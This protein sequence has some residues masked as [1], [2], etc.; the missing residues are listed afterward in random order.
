MKD[1]KRYQ[2]HTSGGKVALTLLLPP[3]MNKLTR[4]LALL[5]TVFAFAHAASAQPTTG[6]TYQGVLLSN[7]NPL[8]DN[9]YDFQC[10]IYDTIGILASA[11]PY[12]GVG[13]T[14]GL[15]TL[16]IDVGT[17]PWSACDKRWLE[18]D[19]RPAGGGTWQTLTPR[20]L[21]TPTPF[22]LAAYMACTVR[23][24]SVS[25]VSIASGQ[26]VK[27]LNNLK[28]AVTLSAGA[29]V[30]L[31]TF[32]NNIQISAT[33]GAG[34]EWAL[35]GNAGTAAGD[36]L[37]TTDY[38]P[39]TLKV[40]GVTA[41]EVR[42]SVGTI[43]NIVG[44]LASFRPAVV[45][46]NVS[47]VVIAGGNAPSG[48]FS[49][50]QP[51]DFMAAYDDDGTIGGGFANKV[52]TDNPD[53]TDAA[54]ATVGGGVQNTAAAFAATVGG[55]AANLASGGR[56]VVAGGNVNYAIGDCSFIGGGS[57]NI[58]RGTAAG[59]AVAGG[60]RN[61]IETN[62]YAAII[63]GGEQNV[64]DRSSPYATIGGGSYNSTIGPASVIAGGSHN[65][66]SFGYVTIS[67]GS[68]NN[69][70]GYAA[71]VG[72]GEANSASGARSV[73]AGGY[74]NQVMGDFSSV[75]GGSFNT[76][77]G[78]FA[79][80]AGGANNICLTDYGAI[81]GGCSNYVNGLYSLAAGQQAI[82]T[83]IGAFV[84]ADSQNAPFY[85]TTN[86]EFSIRARSGVRLN[87]DTALVFGDTSSSSLSVDQGGA[88]ELGDSTSSGKTPFI[89]FHYGIGGS[90]QTD[91]NVRL[92]NNSDQE[93]SIFR[94]GSVTPMARLNASG[95]E[96]NGIVC[97]ASD[98]NR[99]ENFQP[100]DAGE[101]LAKVAALPLSRWNYK[102]DPRSTHIGPMAQDFY[103]AF[104]VG[105]D[106]KHIATVDADGVALAA[107]QGLNQ[108]LQEK[109][110]TI[111]SLKR[112]IER[113]EQLL[114]NN[115]SQASH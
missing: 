79:I 86:D 85:S 104:G 112:R 94:I 33:G 82:A 62:S 66:A 97:C 70:T 47:G 25:A 71:T 65:R 99:K 5:V 75:G 12:A 41:L 68:S 77:A 58:I 63:A 46:V 78:Q 61:L 106:N 50:N 9:L 52:G 96:V 93:L 57:N 40:N 14:N 51:D 44:G 22:A 20:I 13:V 115:P 100:V 6:F 39:L 23:N 19:F 59:S 88:I 69:A 21:I 95:L 30:T 101:V 72:G 3:I 49:G 56:S 80:I 92:W 24:G 43:P 67:G 60:W 98:R 76:C 45:P 17:G 10:R 34:G 109:E 113:L 29:N 37:G 18:I 53:S 48:F 16:T 83:N 103:A 1:R 114:S 73:V 2:H 31:T 32:G 11:G 89:D 36:F 81:P 110:A 90:A 107:I 26:V 8:S 102:D 38:Q 28:D 27:S 54:F 87:N 84:W 55:G 111:E 74:T 15:V 91:Y 64:I 108:R 4:S 105:P 35:S 42:P 7:G